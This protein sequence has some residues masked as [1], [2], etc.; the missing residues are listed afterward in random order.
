MNIREEKLTFGKLRIYE[1]GGET[2]YAYETKDPIDDQVI[3]IRKGDV[4]VSIEA[5]LFKDNVSELNAF[6]R[7]L[8]I[9]KAYIL[10]VDHVA[11]KDYL[12][13]ATL[14]SEKDAIHALR[15]GGPKTLFDGFVKAFGDKIQ[16]ELRDDY[17]EI[18]SPIDFDGISLTLLPKGEEFDV[19]LPSFHA[20][21][22]HML[23]HD[24]HSTIAGNGHADSL[25]SELKGFVLAGYDII[26]TSHYAPETLDDVKTKIAYIESIKAMASKAKDKADFINMVKNAY[27]DYSGLNYL[28][29]T[30]NAYFGE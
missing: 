18:N 15:S 5:P 25:I 6:V 24:V 30:A 20:V 11:P 13:E 26:L 22:T 23:C 27:P 16:D 19:V 1:K 9:R 10:L 3:L 12:P 4:L 8:K 17:K 29:I 21:Y 28:D 2:L 7:G 14:C